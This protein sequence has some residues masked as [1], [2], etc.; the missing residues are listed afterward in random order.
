MTIMRAR[1]RKPCALDISPRDPRFGKPLFDCSATILRDRDKAAELHAAFRLIGL[2]TRRNISTCAN[3]GAQTRSVFPAIIL[4]M[5][6]RSA[7]GR[8][9]Q[10]FHAQ[11]V[12]APQALNR[13]HPNMNVARSRAV[14]AEGRPMPSQIC[15]SG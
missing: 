10:E 1:H 13:K 7:L 5:A 14:L 12:K 6:L 4:P 2:S 3:A 9:L 11:S 8:P 15:E